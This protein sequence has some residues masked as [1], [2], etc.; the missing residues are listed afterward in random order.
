MQRVRTVDFEWL[1]AKQRTLVMMAFNL[2]VNLHVVNNVH[3]DT[4]LKYTLFAYKK[5]A[6]NGSALSWATTFIQHQT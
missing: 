5:P 1:V 4:T 2:N 3:C 6:V